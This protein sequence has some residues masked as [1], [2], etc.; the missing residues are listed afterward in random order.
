MWMCKC[1][2]RRKQS[3]TSYANLVS[4][5]KSEHPDDFKKMASEEG[6]ALQDDG[7]SQSAQSFFYKKKA[8]QVYCWM[9]FVVNALQPFAIVENEVFARHVRYDTISRNTLAKYMSLITERVEEKVRRKLPDKFAL[10]FDGWTTTDYHY[11]AVFATFPVENNIGYEAVFLAFSPFEDD[12]SQDAAHHLDYVKWVLNYFGKSLENVVAIIGDNCATNLLFSSL[13][14][15]SFVGFASHRF[16]LAV[17][18]II[19]E[20]THIVNR[21]HELMKK[22]RTPISAAKLRQ[23]TELKAKVHNVTRWSSV[24]SM[25]HRYC[26]LHGIIEELEIDGIEELVLSKRENKKIEELCVQFRELDSVTQ[27]LQSE[28]C[29]ISEVRLLFDG[30]IEAYPRT[31]SRL[32]ANADIIRNR[33]FETGVCKIQDGR[34]SELEPQERTAIRDL[35]RDDCYEVNPEPATGMSL[36]EKLLKKSKRNS[37][38]PNYMD[39]RFIVPTSNLCERLFSRAGYA[40]GDRR[41]SISPMNF[42]QQIFLNANSYLWSV[43]DLNE[44]V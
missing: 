24:S 28:E 21:V 35:K 22:L 32:N 30:V 20:N 2:V 41:K 34:I 1:K 11:V 40:L 37:T 27:H 9:D 4:H 18:D 7:K 14:E 38:N 17:K 42:E 39:L 26:E 5:V 15:T 43:A 25:L 13:A 19:S 6:Y 10:V 16:N 3:G 36:A 23:V 8:L 12:S 44:V 33:N 31:N 29:T